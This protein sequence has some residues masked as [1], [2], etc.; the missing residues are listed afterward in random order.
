MKRWIIYLGITLAIAAV[1]LGF[2]FWQRSEARLPESKRTIRMAKAQAYHDAESGVMRGKTPE[3]LSTQMLVKVLDAGSGMIYAERIKWIQSLGNQLTDEEMRILKDFVCQ[4]T[5]PA[6]ITASQQL[7]MKNDILNVLSRQERDVNIEPMLK[8]IANDASRDAGVR[9]YALQHLASNGDVNLQW[10]VI[11]GNNPD[12][13]STAMLHLLS[14]WRKGKLGGGQTTRLKNAALNMAQNE[15]V[16]ARNRTTALQVCGQLGDMR[17]RG[18]AYQLANAE[19]ASF[20]LRIAAV[21]TL[22]DLGGD[23]N[24]IDCL[25][26]LADGPEKRLR[27]PAQ[28]ALKKLSQSQTKKTL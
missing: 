6:G 22:G 4:R 7:A 24:I 9:D 1:A 18:T 2:R 10:S 12:L 23:K 26:Y 5:V 17:A 3:I 15:A 28:V 14:E 25:Q 21:A 8:E 13:A 11:E 20:P 27:V 16:S 19:Q